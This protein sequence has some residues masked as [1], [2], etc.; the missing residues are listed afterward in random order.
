MRILQFAFGAGPGHPFLPHNF[1]EHCI[2]YTGTHDNDTTLGWWRTAGAEIQD[3]ARR[4]L[5]VAGQ[6]TVWD[7]IRVA[8]F[9]VARTAIFPLQDL[10]SL[11]TDAR[12]N[13]PGVAE[14]NWAWR[15][16]ADAFNSSVASRFFELVSLSGRA[17]STER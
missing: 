6:D 14:S 16:R 9:S 2:V 8:L 4:Y 11:A 17:Q 5:A 12:M 15:V 13:V 10:L 3:H 1:P 7:L